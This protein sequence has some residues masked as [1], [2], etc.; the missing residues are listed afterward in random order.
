MHAREHAARLMRRPDQPLLVWCEVANLFQRPCRNRYVQR[1]APLRAALLH[2]LSR[3]V[4][5]CIVKVCP[6]LLESEERRP[7]PWG[8]GGAPF[9]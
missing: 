7:A 2:D 1:V 8:G 6:L 4:R 3:H 9:R 5:P